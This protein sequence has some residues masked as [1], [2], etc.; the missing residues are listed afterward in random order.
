MKNW[1]DASS[2]DGNDQIEEEEGLLPIGSSVPS[3]D[4]SASQPE[5]S[6]SP[7]PEPTSQLEDIIGAHCLSPENCIGSQCENSDPK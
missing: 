5:F 7:A 2:D 1:W 6:A 3:P 4:V